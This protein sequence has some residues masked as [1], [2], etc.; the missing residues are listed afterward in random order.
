MMKVYVIRIEENTDYV[1]VRG[2]VES[3]VKEI[4]NVYNE[5]GVLGI[6]EEEIVNQIEERENENDVFCFVTN[7]DDYETC[8]LTV[9]KVAVM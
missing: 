1:A 2:T 7:E 9:Q 4:M 3:V 8:G 5:Y 6:T